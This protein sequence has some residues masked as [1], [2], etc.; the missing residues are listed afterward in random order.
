MNPQFKLVGDEVI[1]NNRDWFWVVHEASHISFKN[2]KTSCW[3][4]LNSSSFQSDQLDKH[5]STNNRQFV[6]KKGN[7]FFLPGFKYSIGSGYRYGDIYWEWQCR[8][9]HDSVPPHL[10]DS[11]EICQSCRTA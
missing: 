11:S 4:L 7:V 2:G 1:L 3:T 9:C 8:K 10:L 5:K 6:R